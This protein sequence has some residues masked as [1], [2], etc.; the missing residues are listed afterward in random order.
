M[1]KPSMTGD[2]Q[3]T[4]TDTETKLKV[5]GCEFKL[6]DAKFNGEGRIIAVS[7]I[8][9]F[10]YFTAN[11]QK[12]GSYQVEFETFYLINCYVPNS[13]DGLVRLGYRVDEWDPYIVSYLKELRKVKP[14]I[15]AGDL[16]VGHLDLD[17]YNPTAKHISKQAG[18]TPQERASFG[19]MLAQG[20]FDALRHLY[21]E[22]KGQFSYWSQRTFARGGNRGIRLDYF[23]CSDDLRPTDEVRPGPAVLDSYILHKDTVGCSDHCPVVLVLKLK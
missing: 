22:A 13:G 11:L 23:V 6:P 12:F 21:P 15:Y 7:R 4:A 17:I 2:I 1:W 20:F 9:D 3:A 18:L 8:I 10:A 19:D 14:V 5:I 16:N